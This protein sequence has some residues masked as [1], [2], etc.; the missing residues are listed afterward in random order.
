MKHLVQDD[1]ILFIRQ[2]LSLDHL[3]RRQYYHCYFRQREQFCAMLVF[4]FDPNLEVTVNH[5][6]VIFGWTVAHRASPSWLL[7]VHHQE[8]RGVETLLI[9]LV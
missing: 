7:L 2:L 8:Q 3:L 6:V 4:G 1:L 9:E 5:E